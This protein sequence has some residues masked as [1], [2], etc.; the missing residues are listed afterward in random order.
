ML[1][2]SLNKNR[3]NY[4]KNSDLNWIK[5]YTNTRNTSA[6][7]RD[8][9]LFMAPGDLRWVYSRARPAGFGLKVPG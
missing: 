9:P 5:I 8:D 3:Q 7:N 1:V 2:S 6:T 4:L